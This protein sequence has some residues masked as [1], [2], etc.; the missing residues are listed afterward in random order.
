MDCRVTLDTGNLSRPVIGQFGQIRALIGCWGNTAA[1]LGSA[2][3]GVRAVPRVASCRLA[4]RERGITETE[5]T[6]EI[7]KKCLGNQGLSCLNMRPMLQKCTGLC[8]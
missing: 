8:L 1:G 6:K 3:L 5:L 7:H 2:V 4:Q